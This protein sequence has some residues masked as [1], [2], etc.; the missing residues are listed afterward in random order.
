MRPDH[1]RRPPD[2]V[3]HRR[4]RHDDLPPPD[5]ARL[6]FLP[7]A[8]ISEFSLEDPA[9]YRGVLR[10]ARRDARQRTSPSRGPHAHNRATNPARCACFPGRSSSGS[11]S[12]AS[13]S[14]RSAPGRPR[15]GASCATRDRRGALVGR[16]ARTCRRRSCPCASRCCCT[17]ALGRWAAPGSTRR[18][19]RPSAATGGPAH[20]RCARV[21]HRVAPG[22]RES[23]RLAVVFDLRGKEEAR[24]DVRALLGD[25]RAP[26][27]DAAVLCRA[28]ADARFMTPSPVISR[29]VVWAKANMLRIV[30]EYPKG[31]G[32]TN[33]PPSDILV[34]RDTSWFA[35]GFDYFL[36]GS[37][38]TRSRCSTG[39]S[40]S[41]AR[42]SSTCAA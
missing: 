26:A 1:L 4:G 37:A 32:S 25:N 11:A 21:S 34:S 33:S 8:Q 41:R 42:S 28:L 20:F 24:A 17:D 13:P 6:T 40:K 5:P 39:T 27:R 35:H 29:G 12:T 3:S 30:K 38:A 31:W 7:F 18:S 23:L 22:A 15:G 10:A 2:R 19:R 14:A 9:R 16:L 36:P